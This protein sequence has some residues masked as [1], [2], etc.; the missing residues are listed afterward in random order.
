MQYYR[1]HLSK[2]ILIGVLTG[3]AG[4]GACRKGSNQDQMVVVYASSASQIK[5]GTQ[6]FP[7]RT[8]IVLKLNDVIETG[9]STMDIQA[10]SGARVR[11]QKYSVMKVS[12]LGVST[13][14]GLQQGRIMARVD[15]QKSDRDFVIVTPTAVAGVRGTTFEIEADEIE[16]TRVTVLDGKVALKPNVPSATNATEEEKEA[17]PLL[18]QISTELDQAEQVLEAG[19]TGSL[20]VKTVAEVQRVEM[21]LNNPTMLVATTEIKDAGHPA[22]E[23]AQLG[24]SLNLDAGSSVK[25]ENT[26]IGLRQKAEAHTLVGVDD[27]LLDDVLDKKDVAATS[28][29]D[30]ALVKQVNES[31]ERN[32]AQAMKTLEKDMLK[33]VK[34]VNE[35]DIKKHYQFVEVVNLRTGSKLSGAVLAQSGGFLMVHSR[36][37]LQRVAI[38]NISFIDYIDQ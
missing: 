7:A 24:A 30:S 8:G 35:D 27:A 9:N 12:D 16:G 4:L 22:G 2:V 6:T 19:Q 33:D 17:N 28:Q 34:L 36:E 26:E 1:N 32:Q 13:Q 29:V 10:R 38:S 21:V 37:G 15:R 18:Q 14:L 31:Y 3:V 5:R 20:S 23:T 11:L 25:I